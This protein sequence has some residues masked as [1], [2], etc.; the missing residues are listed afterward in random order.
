MCALSVTNDDADFIFYCR[1]LVAWVIPRS[2][3]AWTH[4]GLLRKEE[5]VARSDRWP[6]Q[7]RAEACCDWG[8][9]PSRGQ[10]SAAHG[11]SKFVVCRTLGPKGNVVLAGGTSVAAED[12]AVTTE[13]LRPGLLAAIPVWELRS[14]VA[15]P[16][17]CPE[18]LDVLF[19]ITF[20]QT[21]A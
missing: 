17:V 15:L 5:T 18:L 20:A 16:A 9:F 12:G 19:V 1:T 21:A 2:F 4:D 8:I 10:H 11:A 6:I 7:K 3:D 13:G 14:S